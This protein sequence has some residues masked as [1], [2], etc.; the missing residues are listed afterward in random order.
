VKREQRA[1]Q[2]WSILALAARNRQLLTYDMVG[3]AC[4]LPA[5]SLGDFLRPIQQYCLEKA[6]PPLTSIV[7]GKDAGVPGDGFLAAQDVPKAQSDVFAKDWLAEDAPSAEQLADAY[8][9]AVD[10]R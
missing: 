3:K 6:L 7:V 9:R 2:L 5:P 1:Q 10:R 4:G 8:T